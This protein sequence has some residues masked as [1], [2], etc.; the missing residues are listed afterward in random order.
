MKDHQRPDK[1]PQQEKKQDSI[2]ALEYYL[3]QE[4]TLIHENLDELKTFLSRHAEMSSG[5]TLEAD[6]AKVDDYLNSADDLFKQVAL[7]M[8]G[9]LPLDAQWYE[10]YIL[11]KKQKKSSSPE[12]PEK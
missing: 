6:A 2:K 1:A 10:T 3:D 12:Q 7:E 11:R 4:A 5:E 9:G 8:D